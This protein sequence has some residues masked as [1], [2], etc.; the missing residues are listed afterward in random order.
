MEALLSRPFERCRAAHQQQ[1]RS[2]QHISVLGNAAMGEQERPEVNEKERRARARLTSMLD[3]GAAI[4]EKKGTGLVE[5]GLGEVT[6]QL[7]VVPI[8]LPSSPSFQRRHRLTN[9]SVSSF[10]S[11]TSDS[12][13]ASSHF[14]G[15]VAAFPA[16]PTTHPSPDATP[17]PSPSHGTPFRQCVPSFSFPP[18]FDCGP[19]TPPL[20]L[21]G[22]ITP[23]RSGSFDSLEGEGVADMDSRTPTLGSP[24][25]AI[26]GM[27]GSP[28]VRR[29]DETE[30]CSGVKGD[31]RRVEP[32]SSFF[33]P[34]KPPALPLPPLPATSLHPL[35]PF[36][37]HASSTPTLRPP[38]STL[39][40]APRPVSS[41]YHTPP[42][43]TPSGSFTFALSSLPS[44]TPSPTDEAYRLPEGLISPR[45]PAETGSG[46]RDALPG[47]PPSLPLP[48]V[49]PPR[50]S[51]LKQFPS[52]TSPPPASSS[53]T[54][55]SAQS[56]IHDPLPILIEDRRDLALFKPAHA[57][58][59]STS[60]CSSAASS[61]SSLQLD[62]ITAALD[63]LI[64]P[65]KQKREREE[66]EDTVVSPVVGEGDEGEEGRLTASS[67]GATLV[68][69]PFVEELDEREREKEKRLLRRV[70]S[71]V[72]VA[73]EQ[74]EK[75]RA[76]FLPSPSLPPFDVADVEKTA[77][78]RKASLAPLETSLASVSTGSGRGRWSVMSERSLASC[79][80]LGRGPREEGWSSAGY[81]AYK[82]ARRPSRLH[83]TPSSRQ[84]RR[85][86]STS[87]T[88]ST[89]SARSYDRD[90]DAYVSDSGDSSASEE[91][92]DLMFDS[93]GPAARP[94]QTRNAVA[95]SPT[96]RRTK[97]PGDTEKPGSMGERARWS[98]VEKGLAVA[99]AKRRRR[100]ESEEGTIGS[101]DGSPSMNAEASSLTGRRFH[102]MAEEIV[103]V[104]RDGEWESEQQEVLASPPRRPSPATHFA[105]T[106]RPLLLR[107]STHPLPLLRVLS[108]SVD[109]REEDDREDNHEG[110]AV[111]PDGAVGA[112]LPRLPPSRA[113]ALASGKGD[114]LASP[115]SSPSPTTTRTLCASKST[116]ALRLAALANGHFY[117]PTTPCTAARATALRQP[118]AAAPT[119]SSSSPALPP[120]PPVSFEPST[121]PRQDSV[122]FSAPQQTKRVLRPLV[123]ATRQSSLPFSWSTSASAPDLSL[124]PSFSKAPERVAV[125]RA[126]L[127]QKPSSGMLRQPSPL[128]SAPALPSSAA[129]SS[130]PTPPSSGLPARPRP[131]LPVQLRASSSSS[132]FASLP[133]ADGQ[134]RHARRPS[135]RTL[136]YNI[137]S[138][139]AST[140]PTPATS[141]LTKASASSTERGGLGGRGL[142]LPLLVAENLNRDSGVGVKAGGS[143]LPVGVGVGGKAGG[144]RGRY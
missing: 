47:P 109:E 121:P 98:W 7:P 63:A 106:P 94:S 25:A 115:C 40:P 131:S 22:S 92:F 2:Q 23:T 85:T 38:T 123:T 138:T 29:G 43:S 30:P 75:E 143:R 12:S 36:L 26:S 46:R 45:S 81:K 105:S 71:A 14:D 133:P 144:R 49:P 42:E 21:S 18:A 91:L 100:K 68:N 13:A 76:L 79:A 88:L 31:E 78:D 60:S 8:L 65:E 69:Q 99:A 95:S 59:D 112:S 9:S 67:S 57:R 125:N 136:P 101:V 54:S 118:S 72:E 82:L 90:R 28:L 97:L 104:E 134:K 80:G 141:S 64:T 114:Q 102:R 39:S 24:L 41:F 53:Y 4:S 96:A 70:A 11:F 120:T 1:Q 5:L 20:S 74:R 56:S 32:V 10:T 127:L 130:L 119:L 108:V 62:N 51:S 124:A 55:S 135:L 113:L 126:S 116:P 107:Q 77:G 61:A 15:L 86:S 16:P 93:P 132:S 117:L 83:R 122:L 58:I 140:V 35:H 87:S 73:R 142:T 33:H 19:L 66:S 17:S 128:V 129:T 110:L 27:G 52:L 50:S 6:D 103:R 84:R 34:A 139:S 37:R 3:G 48:P 111:H 137:T 44:A 89:G